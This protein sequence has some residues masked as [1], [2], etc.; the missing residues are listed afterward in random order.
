MFFMVCYY[1]FIFLLCLWGQNVSPCPP[2]TS[3]AWRAKKHTW[4]NAVIF[5]I[6]SFESVLVHRLTWSP[7]NYTAQSLKI[8]HLDPNVKFCFIFSILIHENGLPI[9][10]CGPIHFASSQSQTSKPI[11][12][13]FRENIWKHKRERNPCYP[14]IEYVLYTNNTHSQ[15]LNECGLHCTVRTMVAL[16]HY[17]W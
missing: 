9:L 11:C 3:S 17:Q 12:C 10:S 7:L 5:H 1:F 2:A 14:L 15:E 13:E 4:Y 6:W 16:H 8:T